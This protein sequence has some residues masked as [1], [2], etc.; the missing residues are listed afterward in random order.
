MVVLKIEYPDFLCLVIHYERQPIV[1][2]HMKTP[3]IIAQLVWFP[4]SKFPKFVTVR[5]AGQVGD[6]H[7]ELADHS[8]VEFRGIVFL[9]KARE[10]LV[11]DRHDFHVTELVQYVSYVN[12][13]MT[14]AHHPP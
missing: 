6:L 4:E 5:Q 1:G 11:T 7:P 2:R 13:H 9:D 12:S 10:A 3:A 8:L 14:I